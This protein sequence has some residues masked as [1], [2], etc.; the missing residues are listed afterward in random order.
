MVDDQA[1]FPPTSFPTDIV[2]MTRTV[3]VTFR[4]DSGRAAS[5]GHAGRHSNSHGLKTAR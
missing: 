1:L 5:P 3:K 2:H 4:L